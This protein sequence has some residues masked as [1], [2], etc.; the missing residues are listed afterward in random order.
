MCGEE[1]Q[2]FVIFLPR[3]TE[4]SRAERGFPG[5]S[6]WQYNHPAAAAAAAALPG[7]LSLVCRG[8][9]VPEPGPVVVTAGHEAGVGGRVHDA[10]HD[11]VVPQGQEVPALGSSGIP[12]A[13]TYGPFIWEQH[14][15]FCVVEHSLSPVYLAATQT[16]T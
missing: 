16:S 3:L 8:P 15:I 12:A 4:F 1:C 14:V 13:Q 6:C 2:Y 11:A 5:G 10:A 9:P 7:E